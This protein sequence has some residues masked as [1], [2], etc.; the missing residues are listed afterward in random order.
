MQLGQPDHKTLWQSGFAFLVVCLAFGTGHTGLAAPPP[1][2]NH[3]PFVADQASVERLGPAWKYPQHGWTVLHIEGEPYERGYQHGRLLA[4]EIADLIKTIAQHRSPQAPAAAWKDLR[5]WCQA[6]FLKKFDVEYIE[7]MKGIADGAAAVGAR[8]DGRLLDLIDIIA[9]N[10]DVEVDFLQS[11]LEVTPQGL[12]ARKFDTP[13]SSP[14]P[15]K[16]PDR[17]SAFVATGPATRNGQIVLGHIT[18]SDLGYVRYLNIWL[19]IQPKRGHRIV[20]QAFPGAIQSG[21][22]YYINSGGLI[23][24][25]T[26]IKQTKFNMDG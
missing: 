1:A 26:T 5:M 10:C 23:V 11:A 19:D 7:E 24:A 2:L 4:R 20:C 12:D 6:L 14:P 21:M 18:M 15:I 22:D 3:S 13:Q 17:C 16:R 25:E 9:I 8:Y